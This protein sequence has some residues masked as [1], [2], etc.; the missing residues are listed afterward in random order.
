MADLL[1]EFLPE[2]LDITIDALDALEERDLIEMRGFHQTP[3]GEAGERLIIALCTMFGYSPKDKFDK[4]SWWACFKEMVGLNQSVKEFMEQMESFVAD[5]DPDEM[6]AGDASFNELISHPDFN[7]DEMGRSC[8]ALQKLCSWVKGVVRFSNLSDNEKTKCV[9]GS[10]YKKRRIGLMDWRRVDPAEL[11]F[12][13]KAAFD[14]LDLRHFRE[15]S[16]FRKPPSSVSQVFTAAAVLLCGRQLAWG[17]VRKKYLRSHRERKEFLRSLEDLK[18][19]FFANG[20]IS[21]ARVKKAKAL[22]LSSRGIKKQLSGAESVGEYLQSLIAYYDAVADLLKKEA[23]SYD[24]AAAGELETTTTPAAEAP[25]ATEALAPPVPDH[26]FELGK[27]Y[28][29]SF[30]WPPESTNPAVLPLP[31]SIPSPIA[32]KTTKGDGETV[33]TLMDFPTKPAIPSSAASPI[34]LKIAG[35]ES[36]RDG[37]TVGT[38]ISWPADLEPLSVA[39]TTA[40]EIAGVQL[41]RDGETTGTLMKWPEPYC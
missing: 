8:G 3:G 22:L 1:V 9:R 34:E 15:C 12:E 7:E 26:S 27:Y 10:R 36:P 35:V 18:L 40:E 39:S 41:P 11:C 6:T 28:N 24:V 32:G 5:I 14:A 19:S 25:S 31:P 29:N 37:E 20:K 2:D 30:P 38:L 4:S 17:E 23:S 21:A 13:V 33:G 16:G